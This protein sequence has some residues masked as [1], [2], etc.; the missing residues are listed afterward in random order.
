MTRE[1]MF[2]VIRANM[3][4]V[5]EGARGQEIAEHQSMRDFGADSLEIVEVV[6]RS[7]KQCRRKVRRTDLADVRNLGE[8]LDL[9]EKA[10][11]IEAVPA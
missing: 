1:E 6:S 10:P 11:E 7:M 8:L 9:L 5:I 3:Q 4:A 2:G